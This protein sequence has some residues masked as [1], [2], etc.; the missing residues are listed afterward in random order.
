MDNALLWEI[1]ADVR[2]GVFVMDSYFS[3][4]NTHEIVDA[5]GN[6]NEEVYDGDKLVKAQKL[7]LN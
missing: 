6:R 5:F 7:L 4:N 2:S 3:N 1:N